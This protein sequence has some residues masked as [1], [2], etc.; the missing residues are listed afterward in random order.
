MFNHVHTFQQKR[1]LLGSH[2]VKMPM[3]GYY[4]R[5]NPD[6]IKDCQKMM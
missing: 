4:F 2:F 5:I 6:N 3:V 1:I